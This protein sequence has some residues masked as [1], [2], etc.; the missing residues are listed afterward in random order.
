MAKRRDVSVIIMVLVVLAVAVLGGFAIAPTVKNIID[1]KETQAI[2]ER[3]NNGTATVS[4]LANRE[5]LTVDEYIKKY[6]AKG[7]NADTSMIDFM[8]SLTLKNYC[9]F[10]GVTYSDE[11]WEAYKAENELGDDVTADNADS[12]TKAGFAQYLYS[13]QQAASEAQ[14]AAQSETAETATE[15]VAQQETAETEAE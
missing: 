9:A 12:N 4:D 10:T 8:N 5:G 1:T 13:L 7:V 15:D 11:A 6:E 14:N 2:T 3:M